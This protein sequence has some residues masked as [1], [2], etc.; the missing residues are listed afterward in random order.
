MELVD[1]SWILAAMPGVPRRRR[2]RWLK[3]IPAVAILAIAALLFFLW[4]HPPASPA[5]QTVPRARIML[6]GELTP[7]FV[8]RNFE[9]IYIM[10]HGHYDPTKD[11]S[12]FPWAWENVI[13]ARVRG[14]EIT[15]NTPFDIV[16]A[17]RVRAPDDVAY[18]RKDHVAMELRARGA[19]TIS[20]PLPD[21]M[22]YVFESEGYN[23]NA[24]YMRLN[25]VWDN[26]PLSLGY[27]LR[28]GEELIID[29]LILGTLRKP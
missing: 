11:L 25:I 8:E 21:S 4:R 16:V 1:L 9:N 12:K 17:I 23:T 3:G 29:N 13:T 6:W 15:P 22:E 10:K 19:F 27:V 26:Y 2:V 24:G 5:Q 28:P 7:R 18:V 20:L 14:V